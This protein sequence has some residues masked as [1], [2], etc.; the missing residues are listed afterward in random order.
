MNKERFF[1]AIGPP[2]TGTTWLYANLKNHPQVV[3]PR[4][5]EI[6]YFW[7]KQ[8]FGTNTLSKNLLGR[9]PHFRSKRKKFFG[10]LKDHSLNGKFSFK[11]LMWDIKYFTGTQNNK[12]YEGL[13]DDTQLSGDISP[14]Y[15]ELTEKTV[16]KVKKDYP[17]AKIIISLRDPIERGWARAKMHLMQNKRKALDDV[18]DESFKKHVSLG[19]QIAINDYVQLVERWKKHFGEEQVMVFF[20]D[21]RWAM[22]MAS[23]AAVPSSSSDALASSRPVRSETI[24]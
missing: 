21:A 6:K 5:K 24:C 19:S 3:L 1:I 16:A 13:F 11:E 23:A 22:A 9:H 15:C 17:N 20:F 10:A 2:R 18:D 14:R 12:W 7:A 8:H 4:D